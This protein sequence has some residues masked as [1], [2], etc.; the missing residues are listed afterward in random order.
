M[1]NQLDKTSVNLPGTLP[2]DFA[3]ELMAGV[4][5]S[6]ILSVAGGGGGKPY[7]KMD[8]TGEFSFGPASD[9]VQQ[10]SQWAINPMSFQHGH[11]CWLD[12]GNGQKGKKLGEV[13]GP[14][15]RPIPSEPDPIDGTPYKPQGAFGLKCLT[16]EDAG[17]EVQYVTPSNGGLQSVKAVVEAFQRHYAQPGGKN[18]PCPVVVMRSSSYPHPAYGKIFKPEF[19]VV[20][21]ADMNGNIDDGSGSLPK[22]KPAPEPEAAVGKPARKPP[23]EVVGK[24][25][26]TPRAAEA[27]AG[28]RR[29]PAALRG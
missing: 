21:W 23:L 29:R 27:P 24:A 6:P 3:T 7:L 4:A 14:M 5:L 12:P 22:P 16:G 13:M 17:V 2:D 1:A 11:V 28:Q 25:P 9:P 8:R 26:D 10:G 18:Y 20:G 19:Q 15:T